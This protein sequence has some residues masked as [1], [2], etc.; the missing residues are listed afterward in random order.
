M[1][2]MTAY[3]G[4]NCSACPVLLATAKDDDQQ[5]A[6]VASGWSKMFGWSLKPE[7]INCDG[8][9]Q[10]EGR[11]FGHCLNCEVRACAG[12]KKMDTCARCDDYGC[13]KLQPI[14]AL[15]PDI[16][17]KLDKMRAGL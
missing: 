10:N 5:R 4:I 11:L 15:V 13:E 8:C 7:D 12:Q 6:K 9:L 16:K 3:C 1:G 2:D 14:F 17:D